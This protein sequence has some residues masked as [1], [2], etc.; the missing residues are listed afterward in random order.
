[1]AKQISPAAGGTNRWFS[2]SRISSPKMQ[3][4]IQKFRNYIYIYLSICPGNFASFFL[5]RISI[6]TTLFLR[7]DLAQAGGRWMCPSMMFRKVLW[8]ESSFLNHF[9]SVIFSCS[10]LAEAWKAVWKWADP[11]LMICLAFFLGGLS[12]VMSQGEIYP[13]LLFYALIS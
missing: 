2:G 8:L 4:N 12:S 7:K 10:V 11:S 13:Y 5:K 1:M 6:I 3:E 9:P